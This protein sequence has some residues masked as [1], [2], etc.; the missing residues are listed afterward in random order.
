MGNVSNKIAKVIFGLAVVWTLGW[1]AATY[2]TRDLR[3]GHPDTPTLCMMLLI[4]GD[5]I[6]LPLSGAF[7]LFGHLRKRREQ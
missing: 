4:A 7:F 1:A 3:D 5:V 6:L 2:A